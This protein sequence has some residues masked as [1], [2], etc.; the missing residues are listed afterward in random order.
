ML[1]EPF[2]PGVIVFEVLLVEVQLS[3][4]G[5]PT[6]TLLADAV[7]VHVGTGVTTTGAA[8]IEMVFEQVAVPPGPVTVNV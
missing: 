7:R 3:V 6:S 8:L 4:I 5:E 2:T 1:P